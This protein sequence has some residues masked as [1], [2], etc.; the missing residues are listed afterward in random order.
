MNR[1]STLIGLPAVTLASLAHKKLFY[2]NI[3]ISCVYQNIFLNRVMQNACIEQRGVQRGIF[4]HIEYLE[5]VDDIFAAYHSHNDMRMEHMVRL[6]MN[7]AKT[8]SVCLNSP[9]NKY[10]I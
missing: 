4:S 5:Y 10:F 7:S 8:K 6:S 3:I 9:H 2:Q 1:E